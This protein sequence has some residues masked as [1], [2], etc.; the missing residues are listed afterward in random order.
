MSTTETDEATDFETPVG[1]RAPPR[2]TRFP[3]GKSGNPRGRPKG[4]HRSIPYDSIL[5]QMVTIREDGRERRVTAA[6]A[7]ILQL[8]RKGLAGD[9]SAARASL[10]A[11]E[12][13]R[14]RRQPHDLPKVMRIVLMSYG[15]GSTLKVLGLAV[16]RNPFDKDKT[17]WKLQPWIVEAAIARMGA[18][19]LTPEEQREVWNTTRT[20]DK[21]KWP[22]WWVVRTDVPPNF[23]PAGIRAG[24]LCRACARLKQW[25]A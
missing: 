25:P 8:T 16:K 6:E 1:Y 13:A 18:R 21:V 14:L 2:S 11:I 15:I 10:D 12:A 17:R 22:E 4:R 19:K 20:P 5:G 7:F 3:K 24:P 9:S 23:P